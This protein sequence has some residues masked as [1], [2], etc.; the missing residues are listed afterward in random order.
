MTDILK[1]IQESLLATPVPHNA[2]LSKFSVC[3][4]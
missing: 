3:L 1:M 4:P 2:L